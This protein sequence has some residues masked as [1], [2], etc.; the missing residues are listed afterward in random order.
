MVDETEAGVGD[1]NRAT[2]LGVEAGARAALSFRLGVE[3]WK[4]V[5]VAIQGVGGV[6]RWLAKVLFA[7]GAELVVA[8]PSPQALERGRCGRLTAVWL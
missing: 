6:G 7:Q 3:G 2:A 8:D 1:L 4:G 5:R